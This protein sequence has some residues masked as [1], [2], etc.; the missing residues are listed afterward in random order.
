MGNPLHTPLCEILGIRY[1]IIQTAM[2][3]IATPEMVAACCNAGAI[4]FLATA[5]AMYLRYRL[6]AHE[7]HGLGIDS[8]CAP[9]VDIAG[10]TTH[11]FLKNRC[12]TKV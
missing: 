9:M 1:P 5:R 10:V 11:E 2:G 4:G 8:N 6:I 3:W 7:L 12:R